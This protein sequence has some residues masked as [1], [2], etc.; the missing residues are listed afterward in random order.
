MTRLETQVVSLSND[1]RAAREIARST[2][3]LADQS[4]TYIAELKKKHRALETRERET[5]AELALKN[6]EARD[7]R[8]N[9]HDA[10][11]ETETFRVE[12]NRLNET[13]VELKKKL[14][15]AEDA[16]EDGRRESAGG[17]AAR[18]IETPRKSTARC[19]MPRK[20]SRAGSATP[21]TPPRT[22]SYARRTPS[23]RARRSARTQ[24]PSWSARP[25][26]SAN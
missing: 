2:G 1:L 21:R 6:A 11:L 23:S 26:S 12:T 22:P 9:T 20:H 24:P 18:A 16:L 4:A 5:R 10:K 19:W 8:K 17:A 15:A 14:I 25:R 13:I 3:E 7:V